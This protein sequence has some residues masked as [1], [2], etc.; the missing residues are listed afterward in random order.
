MV[1]D[2]WTRN[3]NNNNIHLSI[4][5]LGHKSKDMFLD[6]KKS[7]EYLQNLNHKFKKYSKNSPPKGLNNLFTNPVVENLENYIDK[8]NSILYSI[9]ELLSENN[10]YNNEYSE[11]N[12]SKEIFSITDKILSEY[13]IFLDNIKEIKNNIKDNQIN[14]QFNSTSLEE[15]KKLAEIISKNL[16]KDVST[17]NIII[18]EEI[19]FNIDNFNRNL[20]RG[21]LNIFTNKREYNNS[22]TF[23][24]NDLHYSIEEEG[25]NNGVRLALF[26]MIILFLLF[27]CYLCII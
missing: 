7:Y 2:K 19:P 23:S 27:I 25:L 17:E 26:F 20:D 4:P 11:N 22:I 13:N 10:N 18:H 5:L 12:L 6:L 14:I 21:Q 3:S 9:N 8:V 1:I 15:I 24:K 16:K